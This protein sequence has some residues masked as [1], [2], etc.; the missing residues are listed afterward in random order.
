MEKDFQ[1]RE[2]AKAEWSSTEWNNWS[3]EAVAYCKFYSRSKC[4]TWSQ[5]SKMMMRSTFITKTTNKNQNTIRIT[6]TLTVKSSTEVITKKNKS[7]NNPPLTCL[8]SN[9]M[10][11][12]KG[13][14]KT[15]KRK[16]S[17]IWKKSKTPC[18]KKLHKTK[19]ISSKNSLKNTFLITKPIV[20]KKPGNNSNNM[21]STLW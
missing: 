3:Q 15:P 1:C 12:S 17:N 13:S 18:L 10:M 6:L 16:S 14:N 4:L 9:L 19:K 21:N 11:Q 8:P 5:K 7:K 2:R 20:M